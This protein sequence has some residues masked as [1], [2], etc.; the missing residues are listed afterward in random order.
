MKNIKKLAL[1]FIFIC[2]LI[3]SG[4]ASQQQSP[5]IT[6]TESD[7]PDPFAQSNIPE[8]WISTYWDAFSD[9]YSPNEYLTLCDIMVEL[10]AEPKWAINSNLFTAI[11]D[12]STYNSIWVQGLLI[13]SS[14]DIVQEYGVST[15]S[16]YSVVIPTGYELGNYFLLTNGSRSKLDVY[17]ASG[18]FV[19]TFEVYD[20]YFKPDIIFDIGNS[21]YVFALAGNGQFCLQLINPDGEISYV[22]TG[23]DTPSYQ[24]LK[25]GAVAIGNLSEGLF[26]I[27]FDYLLDTYAYYFDVTGKVAI[28]LSANVTNFQVTEMGNFVNGKASICFTG[29]DSNDYCGVI[30][31]N[32][33][34]IEEPQLRP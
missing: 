24:D 7:E 21:Y 32:G 6:A 33:T 28:N 3:L 29:I 2:A 11:V 16:R 27:R 23:H 10:S 31:K 19:G 25:D 22:E 5:E 30:D 4:C 20:A 8:E 17:N 18:E 34:F 1:I 9:Y 14:G 26:S 12:K 13:N 15:E